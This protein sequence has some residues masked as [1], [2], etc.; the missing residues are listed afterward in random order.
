MYSECVTVP[1]SHVSKLSV[2]YITLSVIDLRSA[3]RQFI[4]CSIQWTCTY[5][6]SMQ[7]TG[8]ATESNEKKIYML[9]YAS[10]SRP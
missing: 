1:I 4:M 10:D 2:G 7:L 9:F 3:S 5:M 6:H 8:Y